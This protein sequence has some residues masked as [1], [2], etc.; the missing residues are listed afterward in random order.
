[1]YKFNLYCLLLLLS[2]FFYTKIFQIE[3]LNIIIILSIFV[4][5]LTYF[6]CSIFIEK[7]SPLYVNFYGIDV[8]KK[9][10]PKMFIFFFIFFYNLIFFF[11]K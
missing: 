1:M 8:H 7:I 6:L 10:K 4:S 5:I 9:E 11:Q 3:A 2:Y